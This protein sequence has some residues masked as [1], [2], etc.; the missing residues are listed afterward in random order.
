MK[1]MLDG[2]IKLLQYVATSATV[3]EVILRLIRWWLT[4]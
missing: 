2:I 1:D 3:I 4:H